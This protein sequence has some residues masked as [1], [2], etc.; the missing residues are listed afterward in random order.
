MVRFISLSFLFLG[1]AF[2]ELSGGGDFEPGKKRV[3]EDQIVAQAAA[4]A[5]P[6]APL[7][8]LQTVAF[9]APAALEATASTTS[10]D[11]PVTLASVPT[12]KRLVGTPQPT[13]VAE[14]AKLGPEKPE[15]A[16]LP[17]LEVQ[18]Q[19]IVARASLNFA[20]P[21]FRRVKGSRVNMR[22]GPGTQYSVIAKLL[23]NSEVE[24]LQEPGNGWVKL[25]SLETG[26]IGWMSAKLLV[27]IAN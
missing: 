8:N 4:P 19:S 16:D 25:Q 12:T 20:E 18:P 10:N 21:D 27:K 22:N 3:S 26:R 14:I 2:Y 5:A 9:V 15:A 24:V 13:A 6:A 17:N 7:E 23:R 11:A 1:W